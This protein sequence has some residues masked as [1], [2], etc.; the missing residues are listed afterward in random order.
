MDWTA[1]LKVLG[2]SAIPFLELRVGIPVGMSLGLQPSVAVA[3]GIIGN[4]AQVPLIMFILYMLRRIAQQAPWAARWLARIDQVAEK[5]HTRVR[6]YGWLGVALFIGIPIPG[7]GLW[8]GAALANLMRLP[9]ALTAV[10][11]ALGVAVSGMLIGAVATGAFAVI[12][13]F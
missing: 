6:R 1:A 7:T 3:I 2:I 4:L 9:V 11:M 8:S 12:R 5:H 13:L 10:A